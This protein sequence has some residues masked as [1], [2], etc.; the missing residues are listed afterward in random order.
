[1]KLSGRRKGLFLRLTIACE[2][3]AAIH[4]RRG[5]RHSFPPCNGVDLGK[6]TASGSEYN[7]VRYIG[8]MKIIG[9]RCRYRRIGFRETY[10]PSWLFIKR[11]LR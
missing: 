2:G 7:L 9:A 8:C 1:M 11:A 6:T 10:E 4:V 3:A 5:A